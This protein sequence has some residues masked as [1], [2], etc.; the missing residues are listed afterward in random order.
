MRIVRITIEGGLA[1]HG[2]EI[3]F[4]AIGVAQFIISGILLWLLF[5]REVRDYVH[6]AVA[7]SS[8][9]T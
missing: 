8:N 3:V 9:A 1:D 6:K 7:Q 2:R 4:D 5:S